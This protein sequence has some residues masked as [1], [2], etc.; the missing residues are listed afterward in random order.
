MPT[1]IYKAVSKEG[2]MVRN[3]VESGSKRMLVKLLKQN[4]FTPIEIQQVSAR[5]LNSRRNKKR[6]NVNQLLQVSYEQNQ[7]LQ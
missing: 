1:Y 6:K 2:Y 4:K 5:S 7:T 3:R